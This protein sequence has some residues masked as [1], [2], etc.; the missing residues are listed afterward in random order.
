MR[1]RIGA[2]IVT[3]LISIGVAMPASSVECW[4]C[5]CWPKPCPPYCQTLAYG[6]G[7]TICIMCEF[8]CCVFSG[9]CCTAG[10][11]CPQPWPETCDC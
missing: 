7:K 2:L 1:R 3:L 8:G 11:V 10:Y 4:D 9:D 5:S 6:T